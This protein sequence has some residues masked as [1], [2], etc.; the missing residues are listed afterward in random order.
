M[1][2]GYATDIVFDPNSGA[3]NAVSNPT[4]NLRILYGAFQGEGVFLSPNQGQ[5]WNCR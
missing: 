1:R 5:T 4:G 3:I 2:A